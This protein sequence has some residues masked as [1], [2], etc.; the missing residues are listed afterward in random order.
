MG[1]FATTDQPWSTCVWFLLALCAAGMVSIC[2][3]PGA[4][5]LM[6]LAARSAA[7]ASGSG[8]SSACPDP[9]ADPDDDD[10]GPATNATVPDPLPWTGGQA[11]AAEV[12]AVRRGSMTAWLA[13]VGAGRSNCAALP[14]APSASSTTPAGTRWTGLMAGHRIPTAT[15]GPLP[16][17]RPPAIRTDRGSRRRG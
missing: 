16:R 11:R 14:M 8:A 12:T 10:G 6:G 7:P 15:P 9:P 2:S 3:T 17:G 4:I 1:P 13:A 5:W